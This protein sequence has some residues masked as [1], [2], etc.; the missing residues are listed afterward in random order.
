MDWTNLLWFGGYICVS[1]GGMNEYNISWLPPNTMVIFDRTFFY[2]HRHTD[3]SPS[4]DIISLLWYLY[5]LFCWTGAKVLHPSLLPRLEEPFSGFFDC[6]FITFAAKQPSPA[7]SYAISITRKRLYWNGDFFE[8]HVTRYKEAL[9]S[10]NDRENFTF[11][12]SLSKRER[13]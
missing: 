1:E 12:H 8:T 9:N 6:R 7:W 2:F 10:D 11:Y 5:C 3:I 13:L 4:G